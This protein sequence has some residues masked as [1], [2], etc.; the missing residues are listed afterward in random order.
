LLMLTVA[1]F[2]AFEG[3]SAGSRAADRFR[4]KRSIQFFFHLASAITDVVIGL[5][6]LFFG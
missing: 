2:S 1:T 5:F 3:V 6:H 4:A